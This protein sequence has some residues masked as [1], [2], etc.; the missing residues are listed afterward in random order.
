MRTLLGS[1]RLL[2]PLAALSFVFHLAAV[3]PS[4]VAVEVDSGLAKASELL[5]AKKYAKALA[6]FKHANELAGGRCG[7]CLLGISRV[8]GAIRR[9]EEAE[10]AAR[11]AIPL[12]DRPDLQALAYDQLGVAL[13]EGRK[14]WDGAEAAFRKA[15]ELGADKVR[16]ARYNLAEALMSKKKYAEAADMARVFLAG[17]AEG[18]LARRARVLL[19]LARLDGSLAP[20]EPPGEPLKTDLSSLLQPKEPQTT[21]VSKPVKIFGPPPVYTERAR[22]GRIEG[23]VTVEAMIDHEGCVQDVRLLRR[24]DSDLDEAT[25]WAVR[26]W[27][28]QPAMFQGRPVKVYYSLTMNFAVGKDPVD[29]SVR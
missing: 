23:A 7:A 2:L 16:S 6:E 10:S 9:W 1:P 18:E 27:V 3:S 11:E 4:D 17:N 15:I 19:C 8:H 12:L 20:P 13:A 5:H 24:R 14:D 25:Q 22:Q 21:G 29:V 26:R 28:F